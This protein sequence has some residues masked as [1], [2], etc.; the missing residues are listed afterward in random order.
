MKNKFAELY[1]REEAIRTRYQTASEQNN[2][3]DM[4]QARNEHKAFED[5]IRAEGTTFARLYRLYADAMEVSNR[6]IDLSDIHQYQ[7]A[8]ALITSFREYG[9]EAFTLSSGWS[10]AVNSAW[11]FLQNGCELDGMVEINS[12]HKAFA[13]DEYEKCPAFLFKVREV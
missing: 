9:I 10:S 13:S 2:E 7:D 4:E 12:R 8:T 11:A 1:D 3:P 6:Y 5:S